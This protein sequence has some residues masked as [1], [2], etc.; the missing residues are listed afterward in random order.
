M[1]Q[2]RKGEKCEFVSY[3]D[4][5]YIQSISSDMYK[6]QKIPLQ[7]PSFVLLVIIIIMP[8]SG[9]TAYY[10]RKNILYQEVF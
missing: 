6:E 8:R 7:Q 3:V 2:N 9:T 1:N 5:Y 4:Y 10:M